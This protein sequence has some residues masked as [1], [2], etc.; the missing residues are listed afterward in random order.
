MKKGVPDWLNSS[1]WSTPN[2]PP[3]PP[4]NDA[5]KPLAV[6]VVE[7]PPKVSPPEPLITS[8][9]RAT[10][11]AKTEIRDPLSSTYGSNNSIC[12]SDEENG[13]SSAN[14][15]ASGGGAAAAVAPAPAPPAA[16]VISRQTQLLQEV[17]TLSLSLSPHSNA[18][19]LFV[20]IYFERRFMRIAREKNDLSENLR[21]GGLID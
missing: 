17:Y 16:E 14:S 6:P 10:S 8:S 19:Q 5:V 3:S 1:L 20:R 4:R 12:H 13:S 7:P 11:A 18:S 2:P 15:T 21:L 9:V